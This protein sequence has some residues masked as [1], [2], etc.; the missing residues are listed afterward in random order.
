[1]MEH[2]NVIQR[3]ELSPASVPGSF[4]EFF[5]VNVSERFA[6]S[7]TPSASNARVSEKL[8]YTC[9]HFGGFVEGD[10][11]GVDQSIKMAWCLREEF[12]MATIPDADGCRHYW[13]QP[14]NLPNDGASPY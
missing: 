5:L 6:M 7:N 11:E 3:S 14:R 2:S 8:C 1:M 4:L 12:L 9:G 10:G 13:R